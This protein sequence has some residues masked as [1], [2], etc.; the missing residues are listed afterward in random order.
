MEGGKASSGAARSH[1]RTITAITRHGP[2]SAG[3]ILAKLLSLTSTDL[4]IL[5]RAF[6]LRTCS[7]LQNC[8]QHCERRIVDLGTEKLLLPER[9]AWLVFRKHA[10]FLRCSCWK[11]PTAAPGANSAV[12]PPWRAP[13]AVPWCARSG[14]R[15]PRRKGCKWRR[16][17]AVLRPRQPSHPP[18]AHLLLVPAHWGKRET[19]M[20]KQ[21]TRAVSSRHP[22]LGTGKQ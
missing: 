11:R 10:Y 9:R 15:P 1:E 17:Q 14:A 7:T 12:T 16:G 3:T 18:P 2:E 5:E 22:C 6:A 21:H 13:R 4:L 8:I 19:T 20:G